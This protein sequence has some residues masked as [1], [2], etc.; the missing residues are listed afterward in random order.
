ME[1]RHL[2]YVVAVAEHGSVSRAARALHVSQSAVSEQIADLEREIEV[3]LF[4]RAFRSIRLTPHGELFLSEAKKTLAAA[5]Q[6]VKVAQG[7]HRGELGELRIGFFAGGVGAGFAR[8][9]RAFRKRHP[10][11]RVVLEEMQPTRQW[12][13]LLDGTIDIGFT[14]RLESPYSEELESETI[15]QDPVVAVLPRD[16]PLAPGPVNIGDLAKEAFVLSARDTSPA[17][18]DK[19]IELCSEAGFSPRIAS[20]S[21]VWSSVALLVEAGVGISL[22]PLNLQQDRTH[23][24]V[25]CPLTSAN[26]TIELVMAWQKVRET[27]M[28][29]SLRKL[30]RGAARQL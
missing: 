29:D 14:R 19:V 12:Q 23:D 22:L 7:S 3:S 24:L 2:R 18:F 16:H 30:V 8:V 4:D 13:A 10:G 28:L 27:P 1:L 20:I 5:A 6:A 17:L 9:I 25:F 26:A 11:I 21:T 15:R